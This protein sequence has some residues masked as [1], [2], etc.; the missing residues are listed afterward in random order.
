MKRKS[1]WTWG[2]SGFSLVLACQPE[3]VVVSAEDVAAAGEP[4]VLSA[5]AALIPRITSVSPPLASNLGGAT[6]TLNG[7]SFGSGAQVFVAGQPVSSVFVMSS[8]QAQ[9]QL[10][11]GTFASGP[12][13]LK[14]V[15]PDGR[16]SERSDVL[17]LFDD[18]TALSGLRTPV[19]ATSMGG[20]A[21]IVA[22]ADFDGDGLLDA[23][24]QDYSRL[25]VLRSRGRG[26]FVDWQ[27]VDMPTF[28]MPITPEVADVNGV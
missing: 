5:Q 17:T 21:Q 19:S 28:G 10:P 26:G 7:R 13:A 22:T 18:R 20:P 6:L 1:T 23:L 8:T 11:R 12:V 15:N 27:A 14:V 2:L 24:G 16:Q 4:A 9:L 25:Y 3:P